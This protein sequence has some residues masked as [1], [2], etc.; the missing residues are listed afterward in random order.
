MGRVEGKVVAITGAARGQGR[1]HAVRLAEEGADIIALD[2][3]TDIEVAQYPMATVEDLKETVRLVE[4]T[5]RRIFSR[6]VDVRDRA[7]LQ[8]AIDD[9][10]AE[11]GRLDVVIPNAGISVL[12]P[13]RPLTAFTDTVDINLVGVINTIH[14]TLPHLSETAS[15]IVVGSM[16]GLIPDRGD[17]GPMGPGGLGYSLAKSTLIQYVN[18]LALQLAP[19][20][21]RVNALHPTNVDTDMIQNESVWRLFRPDLEHPTREEG[22]ASFAM[23]H[24]M[25]IPCLDPSDVSH[26]VVYLAS[27]ESRYVTGNQF[28]IDAGALLKRGVW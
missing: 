28:K 1:S 18:T 21:R 13:D 2:A 3:C 17:P 23:I 12:G 15:V 27:D 25:P 20:G 11:L 9:G 16:V 14:A 19:S 7:E 5:G 26:A 10:V 8:N 4:Q 22:N 24:G 6:Q